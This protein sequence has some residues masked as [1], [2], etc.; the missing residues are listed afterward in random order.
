MSV[1]TTATCPHDRTVFVWLGDGP[2][3][4]T[5]TYPW[6][7]ATTEPDS[8]GH[9]TVCDLMKPA[10]AE[11]AGEVCRCGHS[12]H[13]AAPGPIPA[14]EF[15]KPMPCTVCDCPDFRHRPEDIIPKGAAP[16]SRAAMQALAADEMHL[17]YDPKWKSPICKAGDSHAA[18]RAILCTC[19]CH[20]N[21]TGDCNA[22]GPAADRPAPRPAAPVDAGEQGELFGLEAVS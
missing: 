10:T 5:G 20:G 18:C 8:G 11:E 17:P 2:D 14:G 19:R 4:D 1:C 16:D 3:E 12:E 9:L 15:T 13:K 22:P 7:H 21:N 6:V